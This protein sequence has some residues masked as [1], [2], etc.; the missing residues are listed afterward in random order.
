MGAQNQTIWTYQVVNSSFTITAD[1]G[2]RSISFYLAS[3]SGLISGSKEVV[4]IPS[5]NLALQS[6]FPITISADSPGVLEGIT[7]DTSATGVVYLIG[8]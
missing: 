4:G 2:L 5:V 8:R 3:G 7:I 6:S 1:Y